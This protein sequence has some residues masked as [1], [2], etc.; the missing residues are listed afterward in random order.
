MDDEEHLRRLVPDGIIDSRARPPI[1]GFLADRT[2][3]NLERTVGNIENR[4]WQAPKSLLERSLSEYRRESQEAGISL[5][6]VPARA[7]NRWMGGKG[8]APVFEA[9]DQSNGFFMPYAAVDPTSADAAD[10]IEEL[11]VQGAVAIVFEPGVADEPTYIDD[12]GISEVYESCMAA[13]LPALVMSGGEAGPDTSYSDP[14]RLDR[15]AQ[16]FPDL[17]IV[18]VHGGW[19]NVQ[20]ALGVAFRRPNVWMLPDVYFPGLTGEADYVVAMKTFLQDRFLFATGY[21]FCPIKATVDRYLRFSLSESVIQKV[22]RGN[23][24]RLFGLDK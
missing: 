18:N 11:K 3:A 13:E 14:V 8:N 7:P 19:P 12:P 24:V 20:G 6:G 21:P 9:C 17:K 1:E 2:Y 23:A 4:G 5:A 10:S 22:F 16:R 15:I